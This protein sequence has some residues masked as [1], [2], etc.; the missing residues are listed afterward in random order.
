MIDIFIA[1]GVVTAVGLI[2]AVALA[3]VSEFFGVEGDQRKKDIRACLPGVNCGA[4]GYKGCDDYAAAL[5]EGNTQPNLCIPGAESTADAL[6]ALLGIQVA[7]PK[8]V[9]AFVHCN[10]HCGATS[11]AAAYD[12]ISGCMA[13]AQL[14]GGPNSCKYGCMGLGDCAAA[15]PAGAICTKDGIAH[16]DSSLCLG[17][18]MCVSVCPKHIISLLPQETKTVVMCANK[19]RGAEARKACANAC[20]GCKKCERACPAEAIAI[21]D[22]LAVIDYE[23]CTGC[24]LCVDG[25]PTGC[26]HK[27]FLPDLQPNGSTNR[28][29]E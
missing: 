7:P 28:A 13:A 21:K 23:K 24:G 19:D 18:G 5:A 2:A 4:C 6:S 9:V 8:D 16:I 17:C 10:G 29:H 26:L 12:G 25:C 3:L 15:C 27:V 22:Q 14:Y 20:I 1:L 11:Q